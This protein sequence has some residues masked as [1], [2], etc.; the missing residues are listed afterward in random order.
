MLINCAISFATEEEKAVYP[1]YCSN[2]TYGDQAV[3]YSYSSCVNNNFHS[4]GRELG[5][6]YMSYCSN[7]G[8]DV[9]YSYLSCINSNFD[10]LSRE[11]NIPY[12]Q[13]CNNFRNDELS[14]SFQSCVTNN[15]Q[16]IARYINNRN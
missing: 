8:N 9:S 2:Y 12:L 10:S 3:S 15:N 4:F 5:G 7:F 14:F 16:T 11:L 6:M 1:Q 13:Y